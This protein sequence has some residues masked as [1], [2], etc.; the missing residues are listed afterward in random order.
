MDNWTM[1]I[2]MVMSS[3]GTGN[4]AE[5]EAFNYFLSLGLVALFLL[6]VPVACAK[7]LLKS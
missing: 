6:F 1:P 3:G 2:V 7:I 4:P 5:W